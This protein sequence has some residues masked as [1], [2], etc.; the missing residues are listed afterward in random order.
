MPLKT[1]YDRS[2]ANALIVRS[3]VGII[4]GTIPSVVYILWNASKL[5]AGDPFLTALLQVG[6]IS[7]VVIAVGSGATSF[8]VTAIRSRGVGPGKIT[9]MKETIV[10][11]SIP[12]AAD[13]RASNGTASKMHF[14]ERV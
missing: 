1:D 3:I 11:E 12:V 5:Q 8:I 13:S 6:C 10:P 7:G 4:L 9:Y 2:I 14:R